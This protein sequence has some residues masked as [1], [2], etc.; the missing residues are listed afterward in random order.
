MHVIAIV[1]L[2]NMHVIAIFSLFNVHVFATCI[3]S[4]LNMHAFAIFSHLNM[5]VCTIYFLDHTCMYVLYFSLLI[6]ESP[7]QLRPPVKRSFYRNEDEEGG[8]T[9]HDNGHQNLL[10]QILAQV[11]LA[12]NRNF[13]STSVTTR[14][15]P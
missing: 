7:E 5:H 8:S 3:F 10:Q 2:L 13:P 11:L 6:L 12:S 14:P 15:F 9:A 1:S 4:L